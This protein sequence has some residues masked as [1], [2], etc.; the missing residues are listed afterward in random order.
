MSIFIAHHGVLGQKWGV[1]RY[2]PYPKGYK[3]EGNFIGDNG[4]EYVSKKEFKASKKELRKDI[5]NLSN[6]ADRLSYNAARKQYE[7]NKGI[8]KLNKVNKKGKT[9]S[10]ILNF[11]K[12]KIKEVSQIREINDKIYDDLK[13]L[14]N[15]AEKEYD[16]KVSKK[17]KRNDEYA[18]AL[19][20]TD[21]SL[22]PH[23]LREKMNTKI[24]DLYNTSNYDFKK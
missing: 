23:Y 8:K 18:R 3:G 21:L 13:F 16:M 15:K 10:S 9:S 11:T 19:N 1:R 24:I 14:I 22:F 7:I 17:I 5:K 20:Y 12:N 6:A 4:V 2:Q